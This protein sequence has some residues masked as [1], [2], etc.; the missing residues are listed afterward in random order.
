MIVTIGR[1][2]SLGSPDGKIESGDTSKV[3]VRMMDTDYGGRAM[4]AG[5]FVAHRRGA[6]L[7]PSQ[8]RPRDRRHPR[9]M[10]NILVEK[11][12]PATR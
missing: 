10:I 3:K 11:H 12:L 5:H 9:R 1:L 2:G 6:G 4:L 8:G 7:T